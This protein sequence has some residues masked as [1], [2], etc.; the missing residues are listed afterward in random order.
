M[1]RIEPFLSSLDT[2]IREVMDSLGKNMGVSLVVDSEQRLLGT[3]TDGDIRR[4]ILSNV[5]LDLP[6]EFLLGIE[7]VPEHAIPVTAEIG[8]PT[9]T[10]LQ[11]MTEYGVRHIPIIGPDSQVEDIALLEELVKDYEMPLTAVVMAGGLGTRLRPLTE[12]LPKP[13]LPVGD[14]PV[15][16]HIVTQLRTAGIRRLNITTHYKADMIEEYFK[17][18]SNFGINIEYVDEKEPL[19]TAGALSLIDKPDGP[20]LVINGDI[21]TNV[22]LQ[23]MLNFHDEHRA[24]MTVGIR[25]YEET[26]PFGVIELDG[27]R[28]TRVTEKPTNR[29]MINGG[30]YL[31]GQDATSMIPKESRYDM[32]DLITDL[33]TG[34]HR[35]VGFP[36]QEYWRD[37][38]KIEDYK[39]AQSEAE[40]DRR[41]T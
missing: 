12:D 15:L 31:I 38:G 18:G 32:T 29:Y 4:A 10:L 40:Y 22:N 7:R 17:D 36:I 6:V 41:P 1:N 30:I 2:P 3:V 25:L 5:D 23:A 11:L 35:V 34:G 37:I 24:D 16:E 27:T 9:A 13:M 19:G 14:R 20:L 39:K 33:L 26:V 28:I 8:T 21:V